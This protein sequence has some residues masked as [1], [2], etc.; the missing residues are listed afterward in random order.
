MTD[1]LS[2]IAAVDLFKTIG[3]HFSDLWSVDDTIVELY[4]DLAGEL[5][6]A[7]VFGTRYKTGVTY[8]ALHLAA[9]D[10][11]AQASGTGGGAGGAVGPVIGERAGEVSR[12]YGYSASASSS[13]SGW[14]NDLDTTI[15]GKRFQQIRRML[16]GGKLMTTQRRTWP[17]PGAAVSSD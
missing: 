12:N 8:L 7:N 16:P 17:V 6:S 4:L 10:S 13:G 5:V 9:M 14:Q 3:P 1:P 15:Y 11:G 2:S